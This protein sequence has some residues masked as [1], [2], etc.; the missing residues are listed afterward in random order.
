MKS[1][2]RVFSR[3]I[4]VAAL[5]GP[6][7]SAS[8]QTTYPVKPVRLVIGFSA[9]GVMDVIA[10]VLAE[11]MGALLGQPIV[12]DAKPGA[13][14][15]IANRSVASASPD[16][17]TLLATPGTL[18]INTTIYKSQQ[19][20]PRRELQ[21]VGLIGE[22]PNLLIINPSVPAQTLEEFIALARSKPG[23][24]NYAASA[25]TLTYATEHFKTMAGVDIDRI[26][27]KGSGPALLAVMSGD[28]QMLISGLTTALPQVKTGKVR[29]LAILSEKR[30]PLAPN[31]PTATEKAVPGFTAVTWFGLFAPAGTPHE[32]VSALNSTLNRV[33]A[34]PSTL[35]K[36]QALGVDPTPGTAD[37]LQK[38]VI[39][40]VP[41][42]EKIIKDSGVKLD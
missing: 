38:L 42:W 2:R 17:Y 24:L 14:G 27:Y 35:E 7:V 4:L 28:V 39:S 25:S 34:E 18:T 40:E 37:T 10:R 41:E 8:A 30:S 36:L 15:H 20:D 31:I 33:L 22:A 23:E 21:S 16:G 19:L 9:G 11:R 26:P 6:L 29:A 5:C 32:I 12:I 1:N 13:D 3:A